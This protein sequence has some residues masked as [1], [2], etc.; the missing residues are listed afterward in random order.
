MKYMKISFCLDIF[1]GNTRFRGD[2][3]EKS[4]QALASFK[5]FFNK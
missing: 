5:I 3:A 1:E 4:E 2:K